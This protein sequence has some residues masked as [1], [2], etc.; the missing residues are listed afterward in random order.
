MTLNPRPE[1]KYTVQQLCAQ[2]EQLMQV[3]VPVL[4]ARYQDVLLQCTSLDEARQVQQCLNRLGTISSSNSQQLAGLRKEL[5]PSVINKIKQL[6]PKSAK[7]SPSRGK[8]ASKGQPQASQG[9][10][11]T[12]QLLTDV[13]LSTIVDALESLNQ[14]FKVLEA[15]VPTWSDMDNPQQIAEEDPNQPPS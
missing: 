13:Q 3:N 4:R 8:S 9:N 5:M 6:T 10:E 7:G 15:Q 2:I 12:P 1:Q 14:R 11:A